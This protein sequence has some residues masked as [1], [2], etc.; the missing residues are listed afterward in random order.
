MR[1][2]LVGNVR[3]ALL[4]L[5]G[6]VG[7]VLLIV[8]V[9]IASLVLTR[10][11]GRSRELAV[12]TALGAGRV[13]L[14]TRSARG[15]RTAGAGRRGRWAGC[16]PRG[17]PGRLPRSTPD[18]GIPLL[19]ADPRRRARSSRSLGASALAAL[20]F[21]TLPAWHRA[22]LGDVAGASA[23]RRHGR[24]AIAAGSACV[25]V[26]CRETALAVVLLVGAGL[27]LRASSGC[28]PV[29]LG[30]DPAGVQTFGLSLP[31]HA[32]SGAGRTRAA[33]VD[34]LG[35]R[36]AALPGVNRQARSSGCRSRISAT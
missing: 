28:P 27:L 36:L 7:F 3:T 1:E 12:R 20:L 4:V 2:A 19:G 11:L 5:L 26:D 24:P 25:G 6:A 30:F 32:L 29:E 10:A 34:A 18:S 21:G 16:S 23:K 15:E 33:C 8:C 35:S 14:V 31:E 13:R 17:R 22:A 9:N